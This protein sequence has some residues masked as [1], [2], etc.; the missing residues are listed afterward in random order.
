MAR[1]LWKGHISFGLVTI[2][3]TLHSAERSKDLSFKM[4]DS[5]NNAAVKYNRVNE[6]T[7]E[8]VPWDKIVKGYEYEDGE[9]V[10]LGE[11]DFKRA[12]PEATQSVDIEAFVPVEQ[13]PVQHFEKPYFLVPG[14]RGERPYALLREA[15]RRQNCVGVAKVVIRTK[16]HLA[17]LMVQDQALVLEIL[18]FSHE[19]RAAPIEDLPPND[20]EDLK[21]TDKE[22]ALAEQLIE[23]MKDDWK[24]KDFK[25]DY[26][27]SVMDYIEQK[28]ARGEKGPV[29]TA[30]GEEEEAASSGEVI[31]MMSLLKKSMAARDKES[32]KA[33]RTGSD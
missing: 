3:V 23:S 5:R 20:L 25:D 1:P 9:Y 27:D 12:A 18:R 29:A 16:Q 19:L 15:L 6:I 7:N 22:L 14:K 8:P 24:P 11:E 32:G 13:I 30:E 2:P 10:L 31:D 21:V 33:T 4:I 28:V 17:A 26:Y